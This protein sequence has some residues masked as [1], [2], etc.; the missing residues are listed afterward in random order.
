[1][2]SVYSLSAGKKAPSILS[3]WT[4]PFLPGTSFI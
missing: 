2:E 3:E 1:M 4:E